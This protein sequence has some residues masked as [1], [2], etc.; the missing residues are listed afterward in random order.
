[1]SAVLED[2]GIGVITT[3]S[4]SGRLELEFTGSEIFRSVFYPTRDGYVL[5]V[6]TNEK[7]EVYGVDP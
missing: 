4:D 5:S 7:A 6:L 1:M 3:R 2:E